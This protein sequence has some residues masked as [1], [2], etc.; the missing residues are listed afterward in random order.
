MRNILWGFSLL[1]F[2]FLSAC[3]TTTAIKE[4]QK[5]PALEAQKLSDFSSFLNETSGLAQFGNHYWTIN[6]SGNESQIHALDEKSYALRKSISLKGIENADWEDLSQDEKYLYILDAGNNEG[7]RNKFFIHRALLQSLLSAP[8]KAIVDAQT[9]E[10]SYE[11]NPAETDCEALASV[12]DEIWLFT[13][14][15]NKTVFYKLNKKQKKQIA[16]RVSDYPVGGQITAADY[17]PRTAKLALL[18]YTESVFGNSFV[19]IIPVKDKVPDWS[20]AR[21]HLLF[22]HSQW[23]GLVWNS[24]NRLVVASEDSPIGNPNLSQLLKVSSLSKKD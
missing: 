16:A 20:G 6:D 10:F 23:E 14:E 24:D 7:T 1:S 21:H 8:D 19:W 22:P 3:E 15:D 18:G 4:E 13:K 12:G 9:I 5:G 17:N 11:A 2:L